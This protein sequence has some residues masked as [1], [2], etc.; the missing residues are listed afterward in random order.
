MIF[1]YIQNLQKPITRS[2]TKALVSNLTI[3]SEGTSGTENTISIHNFRIPSDKP[4]VNV[5]ARSHEGVKTQVGTTYR[6]KTCV[7]SIIL[8]LFIGKPRIRPPV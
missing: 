7:T 2:R 8:L 4:Q 3:P 6:I 5:I 1:A